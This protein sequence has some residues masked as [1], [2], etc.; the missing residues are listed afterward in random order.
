[1]AKC[2]KRMYDLSNFSDYR[3]ALDLEAHTIRYNL[4]YDAFGNQ[5]RFN[6][7]VLT[8]PLDLNPNQL[9]AIT[10]TDQPGTTTG[11]FIFRGRITGPNS[12]HK[13]LPN[14]CSIEYASDPE[15]SLAAITL[16]TTFFSSETSSTHRPKVGDIVTVELKCNNFSYNMQ[17]GEYVAL[18]EHTDSA[19]WNVQYGQ[20]CESIANKFDTSP[21]PSTPSSPPTNPGPP[22]TAPSVSALP[23]A[24]QDKMS[25]VTMHDKCP[26]GFDKL[27]V[28]DI[29]YNDMSGD[30]SN[31]QIIVTTEQVEKIT[32]I[33]Q[34]L[35]AVGFQIQ[36]ISPINKYGGD[37]KKSM[38]ANNTSAF[39][40][41]ATTGGS[42]FSQHSYGEA[43]DI[44]PMLNPY[45]K[46]STVDPEEGKPYATKTAAERD[47]LAKTQPGIVTSDIA[48]IFIKHG[49]QWGGN[50]RSLKDWQ[51]FSVNGK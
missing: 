11:K 10:G 40:C 36:E 42:S 33:F 27:S 19:A 5:T 14:P 28:V 49:W 44:N 3:S 18:Q 48:A 26:V 7:L 50:W 35:F 4:E 46:G 8:R 13:L 17:Y 12:P 24:L 34:E 1:M 43:L 22:G 2:K 23:Q 20:V 25:G 51:H 31:G 6:A 37:D 41:R 30:I 32:A 45:V 15:G 9:S 38:R 47:E 39:N 16:H 29:K 21:P